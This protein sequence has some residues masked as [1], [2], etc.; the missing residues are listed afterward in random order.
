MASR[1][2]SSTSLVFALSTCSSD[3]SG[4]GGNNSIS[5]PD[6][7]E[8]TVRRTFVPM[9][10]GIGNGLQRLL[11][12]LDGGAADGVVIVPVAGGAQATV[13]LDLDGNGSRESSINGSLIGDI[14]TGAQ[15]TLAAIAT[16]E[17]SLGGSGSLTATETSPGVIVLDNMTGDGG[18]DPNGSRNAADVAV[19]DGTVSLDL[20]AGTPDGFVDLE[21]TGEESTLG[22]HVT[23][24]PNGS[25]GFLIRFTGNGLNFTIP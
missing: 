22:I 1:A 23:F 25:G 21:V 3:E 4:G 19:T 8:T 13:S 6:V 11:T 5:D 2:A 15:V 9:L 10:A 12:A 24:E 20:A 16:A 7:F 14:S 18:A 17:P